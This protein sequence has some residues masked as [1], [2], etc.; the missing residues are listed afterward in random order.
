MA[1]L[2]LQDINHAIDNGRHRTISEMTG[3]VLDNFFYQP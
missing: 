3:T 2:L 1:G